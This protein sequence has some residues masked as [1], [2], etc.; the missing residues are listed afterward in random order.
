MEK[1]LVMLGATVG[2]WAGWA[3]GEPLGI[4]GAVMLSAVGTGVGLYL[5]RRIARDHF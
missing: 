4:W 1:L 2:G 3:A 5:G